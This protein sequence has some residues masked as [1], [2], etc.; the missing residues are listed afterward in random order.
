VARSLVDRVPQVAA[1]LLVV[2]RAFI[3]GVADGQDTAVFAGDELLG[4]GPECLR[5]ASALVEDDQL[6]ADVQALECVL[7]VVG[8][9][10]AYRDDVRSDPPLRGRY[11]SW[12]AA[13][14]VRLGD[15]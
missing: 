2:V 8:R 7:G 12:G 3:V 14:S 5:D 15:L 11:R 10:A 4:V 6:V 1:G 13:R 9:L